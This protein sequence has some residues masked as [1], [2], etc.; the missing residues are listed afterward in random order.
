MLQNINVSIDDTTVQVL[1]QTIV[2]VT[3]SVTTSTFYNEVL[4]GG[5]EGVV[6]KPADM[7]VYTDGRRA[8]LFLKWK[9]F[10]T[11]EF[12][13]VGHSV[14][15]AKATTMA[16]DYVSSLVCEAGGESSKTFKVA[17]K[18]F[19][20]PAVGEWVTVRFSDTTVTGLPK[21]PV[22][23]GRR[24]QADTDA[25]STPV[26]VPLT[27]PVPSTPVQVSL[28]PV[29]TTTSTDP[30]TDKKTY[31]QWTQHGGYQLS[32]GE[33]VY[34]ISDTDPST[35]YKVT[36]SGNSSSVYCSCLAWK[37]Q[38]LNP[39]V[40]T[41]KHCIAVCGAQAE[42]VRCAKATLCLQ[43]MNEMMGKNFKI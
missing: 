38:R 23:M 24:H 17:F 3:D 25:P 8:P 21:F 36:M 43:Q 15:V 10:E 31:T 13:V 29:K 35:T 1:S 42:R 5:G 28:P 19:A 18:N 37:Y 40:R 39:A 20:A 9:P 4:A 41:C 33:A 34:V 14:T 7:P 26:Q 2:S 11:Q 22:Y 16:A 27:P 30:S 12:K 32:K 6:F